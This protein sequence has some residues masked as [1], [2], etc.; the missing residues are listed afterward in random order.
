MDAEICWTL[1]QT[2]LRNGIGDNPVAAIT[3]KSNP[4]RSAFTFIDC[5][6]EDVEL[7]QVELQMA[8]RDRDAWRVMVGVSKV[9]TQWTT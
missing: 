6:R 7:E 2:Q 4:R 9:Q 1:L 8:L 3:L 5:V